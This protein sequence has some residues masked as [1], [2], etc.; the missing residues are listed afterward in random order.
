MHTPLMF[1]KNILLLFCS[2]FLFSKK[3]HSPLHDPCLNCNFQAFTATKM[4]LH[5]HSLQPSSNFAF[6]SV[7]IV[8]ISIVSPL[9]NKYGILWSLRLGLYRYLVPPHNTVACSLLECSSMQHSITGHGTATMNDSKT[10]SANYTDIHHV[11]LS[12]KETSA[13]QGRR[14]LSSAW[15]EEYGV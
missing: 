10:I 3:N 8:V 6:N 14:S 11:T 2:S 4:E 15:R 12:E 1:S 9:V 5:R 13:F 7:T